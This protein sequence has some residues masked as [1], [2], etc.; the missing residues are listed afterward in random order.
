MGMMVL[1]ALSVV[2][3][4][5]AAAGDRGQ[6][7]L[8]RIAAFPSSPAPFVLMCDPSPPHPTRRHGRD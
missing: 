3:A 6:I 2:G 4:A 1:A 8:S 5:A 7:E